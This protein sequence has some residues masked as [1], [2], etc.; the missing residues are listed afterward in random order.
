MPEIHREKTITACNEEHNS[1]HQ[2][3]WQSSPRWSKEP[4][5]RSCGSSCNLHCAT[6]VA[7]QVGS[8]P[9]PVRANL[10]LSQGFLFVQ[11][12]EDRSCHIEHFYCPKSENCRTGNSYEDSWCSLWHS[13]V[14]VRHSGKYLLHHR[15]QTH[16][17]TV[18]TKYTLY[19]SSDYSVRISFLSYKFLL[20]PVLIHLC[21]NLFHPDICYLLVQLLW[22]L[23]L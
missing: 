9:A 19:L 15:V 16:P 1:S 11:L 5:C 3:E 10:L 8:A 22:I 2:D 12:P 14:I 6:S 21:L 20:L 18:Q 4:L 7:V 17:L 13:H 23:G